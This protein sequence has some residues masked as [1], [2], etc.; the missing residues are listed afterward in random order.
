MYSQLLKVKYILNLE[1]LKY[2]GT[3]ISQK[4]FT[5]PKLRLAT[6]IHNFVRVEI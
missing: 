1:I 2:A 6:A 4:N 5:H 3:L